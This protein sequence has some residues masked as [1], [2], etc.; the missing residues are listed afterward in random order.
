MFSLVVHASI[1]NVSISFN[2]T[3]LGVVYANS[4]MLVSGAI[5]TASG[6]E[7]YGYAITNSLGQYIINEGLKTG[8]YT[9]GVIAAGYLIET[10]ENV[11]VTVGAETS[12][13]NFYLSLSGGISGRVT[14]AISG[15]PLQNV[16]IMASTSEGGTYGWSAVTDAD[17]KYSII[18]NLASGTYNVTAMFPENHVTQTVGGIVVAAGVEVKGIDLALER[19]GIISGRITATPSG[20]PLGNA[21]VTAVS[22]DSQ[23]FGFTQT[24]A[25][26]H[27]R[28]VSGLGTGTY[29]VYA[30]YGMSFNYVDDVDVVAGAE[31]SNIDIE[32]IVSPPPPSG[33]IMGA[34]TDTSSKPIAN[35]LVTAEGSAGSGEDYTDE[36]GNYVI[37]SGLGTGIYAVNASALGY[38]SEQIADVS[39]TV[40]QVT[41]DVDFQLSRIPPEQSGRISG[42]VQG[43]AN[44]IPEFQYPTVIFLFVTIIAIVFAKSFKAK[45]KHVRQYYWKK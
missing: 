37:S 26:G 34:V 3:F 4:G 17:G 30:T 11:S 29:T 32:L 14:D 5:V 23:Y 24:N 38:S 43:D 31:T 18:T 10:I 19:S 28:M 35:A 7:G 2:R 9:V 22:G 1:I 44:P 33:I 25:T 27:Y 13:K 21:T 39:V 12:N 6:D 45:P 15:A 41:S 8:N 40:D 16:V 36:N 20:A 42:T